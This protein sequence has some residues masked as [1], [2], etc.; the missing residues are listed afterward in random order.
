MQQRTLLNGCRRR[1]GLSAAVVIGQD[2]SSWARQHKRMPARRGRDRRRAW[3]ERPRRAA[4]P[5]RAA[6]SSE[7]FR[8]LLAAVGVVEVGGECGDRAPV[9]LELARGS[10]PAARSSIARRTAPVSSSSGSS[11]S[12][13]R[14]AR[15]RRGPRPRPPAASISSIWRGRRARR[16]RYDRI[17]EGRARGHREM[18]L[19]RDA[20]AIATVVATRRS[21]PRPIGSKL[22]HLGGRR[23]AGVGFGRL[24]RVRRRRTRERGSSADAHR[25]LLTYG[26]A[27]EQAF[28]VGLPCGGEI[29]V[30]LERLE[31]T[32]YERL[33]LAIEREERASCDGR[34]GRAARC[35]APCRR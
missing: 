8:E 20:V 10:P 12:S 18:A 32:L 25:A 3:R 4:G 27:D 23:A 15:A 21:A 7:V 29:D 31:V 30:C 19:P 35:Q 1:W 13:R 28:E 14:P 16:Q 9:Q 33:R 22:G 17:D 2:P 5:P 24:R 6:Q 11:I 26:I 34:R